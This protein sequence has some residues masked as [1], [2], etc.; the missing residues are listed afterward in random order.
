RCWTASLP[1]VSC[2]RTPAPRSCPP[3]RGPASTR[4]TDRS[5]E[6]LRAT[7]AMLSLASPEP[8]NRLAAIEELRRA[9]AKRQLVQRLE[10]E[11]DPAVFASLR[12]AIR[13]VDLALQRAAMVGLVFSGLSMG[14]ILLLAA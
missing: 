14:S 10:V 7:A 9:H 6:V 1:R 3:S 11:Q 12:D 5:M 4:P 2:K 8:A 13:N